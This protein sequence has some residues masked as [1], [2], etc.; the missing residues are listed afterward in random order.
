MPETD[1]ETDI[2]V[3]GGG[4]V[5]SAAAYGLVCRGLKVV[6]LDGGD[7]DYRAARGNGG[8]VW[9]QGKGL[10][11]PAYQHLTR[12]SSDLW[13][14]FARDLME[15]DQ[16]D[17]HYQRKG[18]VTICLGEEEFAEREGTLMRLHNQPD[19]TERDFEMVDRRGLEKLLDGIALGEEV[20]GASYCWRD[21]HVDPLRLLLA[22][23]RGFRKLGGTLVAERPVRSLTLKD[24]VFEAA[25][26]EGTCRAGKVLIAAGNGSGPL[27]RQVGLD[28]PVRPQRGQMLVTERFPAMLPL[29]AGAVRQT[30]DGTFQIGAT[31][32]EVGFDISTTVDAAAQMARRAVRVFPFLKDAKLVRQWAA[33]R[34]MTPDGHPIYAQSESH[35][36]AFVALCH[37][38]VTLAAVHAEMLAS[39]VA[40]GGFPD[41]ISPFHHRRFDVP[42]AA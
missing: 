27:A 36:G 19:G 38:G 29:P 13:P 1:I 24:G 18:G 11:M 26:D 12:R 42:K 28:V 21:G 30:A 34:V 9:V 23:Q 40:A 16:S 22:M 31:K 37:S 2:I 15:L 6:V 20:S 14:D 3:I 8:L 39:A 4:M 10:D 7:L 5:G 17:I 41:E 32:E 25:T 33:L 35:P